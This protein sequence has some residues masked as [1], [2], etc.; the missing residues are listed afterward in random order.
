M[1]IET[2]FKN[3]REKVADLLSLRRKVVF[4]PKEIPVDIVKG[5]SGCKEP[6]RISLWRDNLY[7]CPVCGHHMRIGAYERIRQ[8]C[9]NGSFVEYY[10][11]LTTEPKDGFPGYE[12]KL[13]QSKEHTGLKEAVICGVGTIDGMK[14][15]LAVMDSRFMMGSMGSVVGEK[16]TKIVE[17]ATEKKLPVLIASTGGGARMQEGVNSLFQMAKTSAAVKRHGNAGLLYISL[18]TDP[19]TGGISASFAML[20][21]VII[22]EPGTLIGF[23]GKRVIE[24]TIKESLP[25]EFQRSEFLLE[26]GFIDMIVKRQH[27]KDTISRLLKV[28]GVK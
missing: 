18:L 19:T 20:G 3:R 2:I 6:I 5:C 4:R 25:P 14:M 26:K 12:E 13:L 23:A 9:D 21:D 8:L 11:R 17:Y 16:I 22:A 28:H 27:L 24:K 15:A 10:G 1:K 7:V